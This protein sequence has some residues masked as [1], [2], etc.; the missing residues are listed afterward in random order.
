[1]SLKSDRL[2]KTINLSYFGQ[3]AEEPLRF[4]HKSEKTP[5]PASENHTSAEV[6]S[7]KPDPLIHQSSARLGA[8]KSKIEVSP[9]LPPGKETIT[10][11][12][13]L[14][15]T[16]Y[17]SEENQ[18]SKREDIL[19]ADQKA[20]AHI[21]VLRQK[22]LKEANKKGPIEYA[23]R[24]IVIDKDGL[25]R[26]AGSDSKEGD[27]ITKLRIAA[28]KSLYFF[29]K[30]ILNRF[31]L[32][33]HFHKEVC[34]FLQQIPPFRKLTMMPREHAKTAIVSG[35]LPLHIII[36]PAA[37]NIYFPGL[38]GS[39]CRIMLAGEN[40]RMA[41]KNLRVLESIHSTN[42][43]FRSLWPHRVWDNPRRQSSTWNAEAL[44]FP[45]A[46]EWPDPTIWAIG[47]DGAITGARPN[48]M[49]K[50]DLVSVE[51]A[52]S[53]IVMDSA[54]QWHRDSRALLDS[55]EV[56]SGLQ[57]LEFIIG[58]RWS[59]Y[60]LYS[61]IIENDLT[62]EVI[63]KKYWQIIQDGK[64]LWPEKHTLK[65][66]EQ[67]QREHGS[68]FFLLYLNSANDPELTDFDLD[69][70]RDFK[71]LDGS[72]Y[73]EKL[74]ED[75]KLEKEIMLSGSKDIR[76]HHHLRRHSGIPLTSEVMS[77]LITRNSYFNLK[78]T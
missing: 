78:S 2:G 64:I 32:T 40:M 71:L 16:A 29:L 65:S 53:D 30:G 28:E 58:T 14:A 25:P 67:L 37:S 17:E 3:E 36:Q 5:S 69:L 51:A 27:F 75:F 39:E 22:K 45:R 56:E 9:T 57:S 76:G 23:M 20:L 70:V 59:V 33:S 6:A 46:N 24:E 13:R 1:M 4:E 62:V 60:D 72:I 73:F 26:Q 21:R 54:I 12:V 8:E 35:G 52:N 7:D 18:R 34:S 10:E 66:I 50:D 44:I 49:I 63:N 11:T 41:K 74:E 19:E 47:V 31:F 42:Q 48:V 43:L 38:E 15:K 61:E 77:E 55:Y 68:M